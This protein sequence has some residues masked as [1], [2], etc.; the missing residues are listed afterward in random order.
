MEWNA[1]DGENFTNLDNNEPEQEQ[2]DL[3]VHS[4]VS[5]PC[6]QSI[7]IM[8]EGS[9]RSAYRRPTAACFLSVNHSSATVTRIAMNARRIDPAASQWT[10]LSSITHHPLADIPRLARFR[11]PLS[12]IPVRAHPPN[13]SLGGWLLTKS[14]T[15][16][17]PVSFDGR[18]ARR[19]PQQ[20]KVSRTLQTG[21]VESRQ[22]S[23]DTHAGLQS[24]NGWARRASRPGDREETHVEVAE[25]S[26]AHGDGRRC[27]GRDG[28]VGEDWGRGS[29]KSPDP[30]RESWS[31]WLEGTR[32]WLSRP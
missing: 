17:S 29:R 5:S 30:P 27:R 19:E 11:S 20:R 12:S 14:Y 6:I 32:G 16:K 15:Q 18:G 1:T 26:R 23:C 8:P 7:S 28:I 13:C 31:W 22:K 10:V 2:L 24:E 25:L 21:N 9:G 3:P 4:S